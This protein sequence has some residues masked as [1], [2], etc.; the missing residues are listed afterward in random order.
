MRINPHLKQNR[1]YSRHGYVAA[2]RKKSKVGLVVKPEGW[3]DAA[4]HPLTIAGGT[5]NFVRRIESTRKVSK[6]SFMVYWRHYG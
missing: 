6:I 4:F 2:V 3:C 1:E 5:M